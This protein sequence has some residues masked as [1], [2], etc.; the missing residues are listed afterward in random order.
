[1]FNLKQCT[2]FCPRIGQNNTLYHESVDQGIY[3]RC[4]AN[5]ETNSIAKFSYHISTIDKIISF[6]ILQRF[7]NKI[8]DK[9][10]KLRH[11]NITWHH[12]CWFLD[13]EYLSSETLL[14]EMFVE[15]YI[16]YQSSDCWNSDIKFGTFKFRT[17]NFRKRNI[18][19]RISDKYFRFSYK[20]FRQNISSAFPLILTF[21]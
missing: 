9:T 14:D 16:N 20:Y 8:Y 7:D 18:F 6:F 1:M 19:Q 15:H 3:F 11:M 13:K 5:F 17:L 12:K 10:P 4:Y 21:Q 2:N